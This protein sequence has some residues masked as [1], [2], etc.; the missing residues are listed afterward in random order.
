VP[1]RFS[2]AG[3]RS[4]G[5]RHVHEFRLDDPE[6]DAGCNAGVDRI[7]ACLQNAKTGVGSEI[8][9]AL[10]MWRV[11]MIVGRWAFMLS[12]NLSGKGAGTWPGAAG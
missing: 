12:L 4:A 9:V 1:W 7:A 6:R 10:I 5:L 11:P 2:A 3:R 8:L